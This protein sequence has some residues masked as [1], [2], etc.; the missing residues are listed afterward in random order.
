MSNEIKKGQLKK[1]TESLAKT[2]FK[3]SEEI[4]P[5]LDAVPLNI[6]FCDTDLIIKYLNPTSVSTL[7]KIENLLPIPAAQVLG[8]SIDAFHKNPKHQQNILSN[9][10]K[11]LPLTSVIKLGPENLMLNVIPVFL[12]GE[13]KGALVSWEVVT[14]SL[15][16]QEE[17]SNSRSV[18]SALSKSQAM[19]EF[20]V[21]GTILSANDNFLNAL[22]YRLEEIKGKH[23]SMFCDGQFINSPAYKDF[24]R[25]LREG[26]FQAGEFRRI[27]KDGK[28]VW[29]Q[30]SYNPVFD[31]AGKVIKVVKFASD[32]TTVKLV[33]LKTEEHVNNLVGIMNAI[34]KTQGVIEFNLDGIVQTANENFLNVVGYRLEEIQGKH[35]SMLCDA[36]YASTAAYRD[37][38]LK[39]NRGDFDA[40][41]YK[42]IGKGGKEIWIQAAYNPVFDNNGKVVKVVKFATEITRQKQ[43]AL[44]I[45]RSLS[46]AERNLAAAAEELT[47]TA[48]QLSSNATRTTEQS[49]SASAG[50]EQVSKGVRT[51]ATNTEEMTASIKEISK[52]T[53]SAAQMSRD[54]Q[55]KAQET[56]KIINKLGTSSHEIGTVVKVIS[57]IA[58][59]T[60]LLALNAT[61]EAA[62]AGD[63]GKGF[64]VVAN[65]VKE[66]AKQTAKATEE[67]STKIG[68]IQKDTEGA[69]AAM[70]EI[71]KAIEQL[72][73]ISVTISAAVEEQTATTNE[74]TRIVV[75]SSSAVNN[76]ATTIKEVSRMSSESSTG[77]SQTLD[78]AKSLSRLA[79][80][81]SILV[82]KVE[83]TF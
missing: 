1:L 44:N 49:N 3:D 65:E 12:E 9:P 70:G 52:S 83:T 50:A 78:A 55:L 30:A 40:G 61:I 75:E 35:H 46:E 45:I 77:A 26:K 53:A 10:I 27:K 11:N 42:R 7:E 43:E 73:N 2:A 81:L 36:E 25:D 51:V 62:R 21:E 69:V 56:N 41:Q 24:W 19:I 33:S 60:N 34:S 28:D 37:F 23:H 66:L 68:A 74:V 15:K 14:E 57:S 32:I 67:I 71:A 8:S 5:I 54:S 22:G 17:V 38:W 64:A 63:A 18:T 59:Q 31:T 58:Q 48:T 4:F 76:V 39:L 72:N 82:K 6:M 29:I 16:L 13:Y 79:A 20:D 47:A 80:E